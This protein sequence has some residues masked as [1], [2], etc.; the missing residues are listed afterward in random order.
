MNIHHFKNSI[1]WK[2]PLPFKNKPVFFTK[3]ENCYFKLEAEL[4]LETQKYIMRMFFLRMRLNLEV[5]PNRNKNGIHHVPYQDFVMADIWL[6][7]F[8]IQYNEKF[9]QTSK[10]NKLF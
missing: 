3:K 10:F 7:P 6:S 5:T 1:K 8:K 2:K 4:S 9:K